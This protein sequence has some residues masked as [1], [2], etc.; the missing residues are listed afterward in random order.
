MDIQKRILHLEKKMGSLAKNCS[1]DKKLS[2]EVD[3]F[4]DLLTEN[5]NYINEECERYNFLL[6][7]ASDSIFIHNAEGVILSANKTACE[8]YRYT[9]EEFQ[10]MH[11]S[12]LDLA[13]REV[14]VLMKKQL[15]ILDKTGYAQFETTHK[16]GKGKIFEVE[17]NCRKINRNNQEVLISICRDIT[18][19][20]KTG[21]ALH[22]A[23]I[24]LEKIIRQTGDGIIL[25]EKTGKITLWNSGAEKVFGVK[26]EEAVGKKLQAIQYNL[27]SGK[28][29]NRKLINQK[30]R[31]YTSLEHPELYNTG[32]ENEIIVPGKGKRIIQAIVFP[33]MFGPDKYI[34]CSAVRDITDIKNIE[35]QLRDLNETK[36]KIFSIIAHDLKGSLSAVS[37]FSDLLLKYSGHYD[38]E[39]QKTFLEQ[40]NSSSISAL[41]ILDNLLEWASEQTGKTGF[42]PAYLDLDP[43]L[44]EVKDVMDPQALAKNI[45]LNIL[46]RE[47]TDIYADPNL[48]KTILRN[49]VSNAIK[50]GKSKVEISALPAAGSIEITVADDG[51]GISKKRAGKLFTGGLAG[52]TIGT[53]GEKGSGLGLILCRE[54]V[55]K[56]GGKIRAESEFGKGSRFIFSLPLKT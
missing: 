8:K 33:I 52:T 30:F 48:L 21:E 40:I 4:R 1:T 23:R 15:E 29:K 5:L 36:D 6:D 26:A 50:F 25:Y 54:F 3:N 9:A 47:K 39:K 17:I 2:A 11:I 41:T 20:K 18:E 27:F 53:V 46:T 12:K 10:G 28:L 22:Q 37:G 16:S 49:L 44:Q 31:E 14:Y 45:S 38:K 43:L 51:T 24:K 13:G 34:F 19:R 56:H 32:F 42:H 7:H 55:E 35:Q